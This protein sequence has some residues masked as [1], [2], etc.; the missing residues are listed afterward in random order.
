MFVVDR[1]HFTGHTCSNIYNGNMHRELDSDRIVAVEIINAI[2]DKGTSHITY[3]DG[4]NLIPFMR[5]FF[6]HL[7]GSATIKD[8]LGKG[9]LEDVDIAQRYS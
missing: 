5:V 8:R 9:D 2:I 6:A 4:T 7:N 3:L 1:F